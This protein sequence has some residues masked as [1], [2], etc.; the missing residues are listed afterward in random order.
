[1]EIALERFETS[2]ALLKE[3]ETGLLV[4]SQKVLDAARIE[5]ETGKVG[6]FGLIDAQRTYRAVQTER[7][8]ALF[9]HALA[10]AQLEH[11]IGDLP[12]NLLQ[13]IGRGKEISK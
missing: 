6:I 13:S 11:S 12:A 7:L 4:K 1:M 3:Y 9:D 2:E 10:D 5:L 8:N